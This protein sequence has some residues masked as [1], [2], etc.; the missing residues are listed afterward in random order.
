MTLADA[1]LRGYE[2]DITVRFLGVVMPCWRFMEHYLYISDKD[3]R[4]VPFHLNR[5]QIRLY[6]AM[7]EQRRRGIPIRENVLKARQMGFTTFISALLFSLTMFEQ[8][9]RTAV[10]ADIEDHAHNIFAK[11]E[12]FYRHLD[13][14][15]PN[16]AQIE[17]FERTHPGERSRLSYK[18]VLKANRGSEY[19]QTKFGNSSIEV[20]VAGKSA[21]RSGTYKYLH[22]SE[23]AFFSNLLDTITGV[24]ATVP[25]TN[26][27]S[28]VVFETTANG[29]NEYKDR[30]DKDMAGRTNYE[31]FFTPW[32]ETP[33]YSQELLRGQ[34]MPL[35]EEWEYQKQ[36]E[37]GLTDPQMLWYHS[38]YMETGDRQKTLQEYPFCPTDAFMSTGQ[39]VFGSDE[40]AMMKDRVSRRPGLGVLRC[41]VYEYS[42]HFSDRGDSI[43]LTGIRWGNRRNGA[44]KIYEEPLEGHPY[45]GVCDPNNGGSDDCA[46]QIVDNHTLRQVAVMRANDMQLDEVAYQFYCLG[47]EYNVALLSNE[48]NLGKTVME[49]LIKLGYPKLYVSQSLGFDDYRQG[50]SS[51]FG[52]KTEQNNRQWMIDSLRIAF[53]QDPWMISDYE[54]LCQMET[55]Q[56]VRHEARSGAVTYK[57]EA[58]AGKHD[59]LVTSLMA[60][61]LVRS[62][63]TTLIKEQEIGLRK[64]L[65]LAQL[66]RK[67]EERRRNMG[68]SRKAET[69]T[70]ID[71]NEEQYGD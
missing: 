48:M 27:E 43:S 37:Y 69:A 3:F 25:T 45:V 36:R 54:T 21:G 16:K 5:P 20:V 64:E 26:R 47:M 38:Q 41:G 22:M 17:E 35:L 42:Q 53:R 46:I 9:V 63:Q 40:V 60:F 50:M 71:F 14:S 61:F 52:H 10:M 13:D 34:S 8:N 68:Q 11:Y 57:D 28:I 24:R 32:F 39:C 2:R 51:R 23:V 18:P 62:Q 59:D 70:G 56:K 12:F 67:L 1:E 33:E 29:F 7:C 30:W 66:E 55:F 49:Y 65:T 15:N 4:T 19:M 6:R 31:A 58:S 44:I